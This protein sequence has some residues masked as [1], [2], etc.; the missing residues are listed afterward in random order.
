MKKPET[1]LLK[2]FLED[3][4]GSTAV[5]FSLIAVAFIT[6]L[7]GIIESGRLFLAW[8]GFQYAV[9]SVAR[10]AM[11]DSEITENEVMALVKDQLSTFLMD[12]DNATVDVT[13]P[14]SG[15]LEFIEING[16]YDY[17]VMVP[18]LPDSWSSFDLTAK[19]R[20]VRS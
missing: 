11:V 4:K 2:R 17:D 18:F 6:L 10:T 5:E 14:V 7:F 13:F 1:K 16:S 3:E 9:E 19:S 8:N 15:S 20:L 12:A